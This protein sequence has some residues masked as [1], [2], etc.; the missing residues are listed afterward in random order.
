MHGLSVH[1]TL[2]AA[3][4]ELPSPVPGSLPPPGYQFQYHTPRI[5]ITFLRIYVPNLQPHPRPVPPLTTASAGK[6]WTCMEKIY[7]LFAVLY[8]LI[9]VHSPSVQR[10]RIQLFH[11]IYPSIPSSIHPSI[12]SIYCFPHIILTYFQI[13][14]VHAYPL[15]PSLNATPDSTAGGSFAFPP[16]PLPRRRRIYIHVY[17]IFTPE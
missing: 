11:P 16:P 6:K 10:M 1:P 9:W 5:S 17:I 2:L 3:V 8:R 7:G 14:L 4:Q 13:S 12:Y 15:L